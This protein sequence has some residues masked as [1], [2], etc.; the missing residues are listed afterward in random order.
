MA[1]AISFKFGMI[2]EWEDLSLEEEL[3]EWDFK[4][5]MLNTENKAKIKEG[6]VECRYVWC[7]LGVGASENKNENGSKDEN[8]SEND[9]QDCYDKQNAMVGDMK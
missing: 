3:L 9:R 7:E 6:G 4:K 1:L 8:D 2:R 5:R